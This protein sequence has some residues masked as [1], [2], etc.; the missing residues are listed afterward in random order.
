VRQR[1]CGAACCPHSGWVRAQRG[2]ELEGRAA[3]TRSTAAAAVRA[4]HPAHHVCCGVGARKC[5]C[6]PPPHRSL[7]PPPLQTRPSSWRPWTSASTTWCVHACICAVLLHTCRLPAAVPCCPC[8]TSHATTTARQPHPD[9][10]LATLCV[11]GRTLNGH[12]MKRHSTVCKCQCITPPAQNNMFL[13]KEEDA[14][15]RLGCLQQEASV[16]R[17]PD[18]RWVP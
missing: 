3:S 17:D 10:P 13:E 8:N 6:A 18:T 16:V 2:G 12:I 1:G 4:A 15:I 5:P 9:T 14:V 11:D 7:P